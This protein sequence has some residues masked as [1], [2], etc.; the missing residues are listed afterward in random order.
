[1]VKWISWKIDNKNNK[2]ILLQLDDAHKILIKQNQEY[3]KVIIETLIFTAQQNIT[4]R[5]VD[6]N[7]QNLSQLSD[8]NRRNFLELFYLRGKNIPWLAKQLQNQT[9]QWVSPEIENE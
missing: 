2:S 4:Q 5:G 9:P 6:E 8:T 7:R 1:M 3:L